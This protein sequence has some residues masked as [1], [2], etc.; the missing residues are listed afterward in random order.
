MQVVRRLQGLQAQPHENDFQRFAS[1]PD[2]YT[3]AVRESGDAYTFYFGLKRFHGERVIDEGTAYKV[4]KAGMGI[5][6]VVPQ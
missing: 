3:Y 6:R 2:S 1:S 4:D 5:V